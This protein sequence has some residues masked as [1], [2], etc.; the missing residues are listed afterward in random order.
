MPTATSPDTRTDGFWGHT[1]RLVI[2]RRLDTGELA[3]VTLPDDALG[4]G[5]AEIPDGSITSAKIADK[6]IQAVD[7]ADG[8]IGLNSTLIQDGAINAAKIQNGTITSTKIADGTIE[9]V[10]MANLII[11]ATALAADAVTTPKIADGA[12]TTAKLNADVHPT[13]A[14]FNALVARV[15]ALE[16]KVIPNSI[17]DLIYSG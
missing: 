4:S 11:D 14:E 5:S 1:G 13:A 2:S 8:V 15:A 6:T 3:S 10:D 17:E 12:V 9:R 16:A 7:I